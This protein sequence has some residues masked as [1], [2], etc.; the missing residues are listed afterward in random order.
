ML[1]D[2]QRPRPA[3]PQE[4]LATLQRATIFSCFTDGQRQQLAQRTRLVRLAAG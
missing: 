4:L 2:P 3:H 1:H